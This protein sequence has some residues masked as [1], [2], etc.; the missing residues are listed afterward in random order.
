MRFL[1]RT[2]QTFIC[3]RTFSK[4]SS[5]SFAFQ[6]L[7]DTCS[8]FVLIVLNRSCMKCF[9]R[10]SSLYCK[11]RMI[12]LAETLKWQRC[13]DFVVRSM[14]IQLTTRNVFPIQ[15]LQLRQTYIVFF[16]VLSMITQ[17]T[18]H[19]QFNLQRIKLF[20]LNVAI[21]KRTKKK[22]ATVVF[23]INN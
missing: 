19:N 14:C 16:L 10:K 13:C 9:V 17:R 23:L 7:L 6:V 18:S 15:K 22:D 2:E 11:T 1:L 4:P 12:R 3:Y 5:D 20:I 21:I 8:N